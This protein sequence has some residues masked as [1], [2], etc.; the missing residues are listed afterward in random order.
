M[1]FFETIKVQKGEIQNLSFHN[2][3]LNHT[4]Q[5]NFG[6]D[7]KIDLSE[8]IQQ[9][10]FS[11]ERCRVLYNKAIKEIQFFTL[12]PRKIQSLKILH[13]NITYNFKNTDRDDINKLFTKREACDDILLIKKDLVTDTSIANIAIHDGKQWITPKSPLLKGTFRA[14][15][16]KKQFLLEKDVKIKDIK[17]A[18]RF[19]LMNAL[20]GFQEIKALKIEF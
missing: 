4:I 13:T 16:I 9:K 2:D 14:S 10:D 8:H 17:K 3:R 11:K 1:T 15:L 20:I 12:L 6:I 5:K 18:S 7:A 19:A